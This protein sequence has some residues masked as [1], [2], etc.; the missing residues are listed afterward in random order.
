MNLKFTLNHLIK[1]IYRETSIAETMAINEA[2]HDDF[3]LREKYQE[4]LLGFQQ[5][6]KVKFNPSP[7]AIQNILKYSEQRTVETH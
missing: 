2:L 5:L 6:P 3:E 1:Y 4:L 7:A